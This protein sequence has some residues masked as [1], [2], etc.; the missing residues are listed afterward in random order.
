[1]QISRLQR[2]LQAQND[3]LLEEIRERQLMEEK[4]RSSQSEIRA[5]FEA[6]AD[7]VLIVDADGNT[8]KVA[9]TNPEKLYPPGSDII[10]RTVEIFFSKQGEIFRSHIREALEKQQVINCEYSLQV[11]KQEIWF[12]ASIAP[13][14]ENTVAWVARDI[15]DRKRAE[16]ALQKAVL[17]A[18]AANRA[19]SE[20]L[21][22][23][24]HELRTPLNAILGFSQIMSKDNSLSNEHQKNLSI[25]NR[26][27]EHLLALI[28][29]ILE[30]S[31]IEAGRTN[32]TESSFD[33][34]Q[35][36]NNL[37]EMLE[38][39]ASAKG[40]ELIFQ[41]GDDI[42][43]YVKADEGKLRQVLLNLL[44]NAIKF[45]QFGRV[46]LRV[47]VSSSLPGVDGQRVGVTTTESNH[48]LTLH[49]AVEDTGP[50]I[51]PEEMYLLFEA[52]GQTETG[53]KS[54]QGT[55]LGL[56]ISQKYVQLMGGK[57]Q[58]S[59][60]PGRGSIF[61]FEIPISLAEADS[62]PPAK[63]YRQIIHL[64]PN[65]PEYRI[66]IVDDL[67]ESRLLL[68]KILSPIGFSVCEAENGAEAVLIWKEWQPHLI[69]MDIRM[70]VMDGYEATKKI[71]AKE[72]QKWNFSESEGVS[73][74]ANMT[75][76]T[77]IIALTASAFDEQR[78]I[79]LSSGCDDFVGKP[80]YAEVLLEKISQHL[81]VEYEWKTETKKA[82][83]PQKITKQLRDADLLNLLDKMPQT[84]IVK[85]VNA[86][87][88][89]SD[90]L[91]F[92]LLE[93]IPFENA[94]LTNSLRDLAE[95]FQFHKI[96]LLAEETVK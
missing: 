39:K 7:I 89:C 91:I 71:R 46:M 57:I 41:Y 85:L 61:A 12:S 45:T 8:I 22:S 55:G 32:F 27:G 90:D 20:F 54:Q 75:R 63:P 11:G 74:R 33:I 53:R 87:T 59:T 48:K 68:C 1:L 3:R 79:T 66:L 43:Q 47:S 19:K 16:E 51:D 2:K 26:A 37:E 50:G 49:F 21:A 52:F 62:V 64:A 80:F 23:M 30:V 31:K 29:D 65:Q 58:V 34:R 86:A 24:S 40:L 77:I 95:N 15:R 88:E 4:L 28:D 83:N 69:L 17:A 76:K 13:T 42:P 56:P 60:T 94:D 10:D 35:L 70:P 82:E 44:G 36:L 73:E 96:L 78:K 6:M 93:Q 5:F 72:Q 9:P 92:E 67:A 38:L 18:D 14:S 81:G 84:W 25:I